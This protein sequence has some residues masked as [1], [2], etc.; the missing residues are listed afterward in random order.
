MGEGLRLI[1]SQVTDFR[2]SSPALHETNRF[3]PR[4]LP[5]LV[6]HRKRGQVAMSGSP[7]VAPITGH[8]PERI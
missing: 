7:D 1:Q 8:L 5:S 3:L 2:D 4:I 6:T